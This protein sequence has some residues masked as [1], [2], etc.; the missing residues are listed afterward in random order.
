MSKNLVS[1]LIVVVFLTGCQE[2]V[3]STEKSQPLQE[4]EVTQ[5]VV[6]K[7]S[8]NKS[9]NIEKPTAIK[10]QQPKAAK[11]PTAFERLTQRLIEQ[12]EIALAAERF[13][14]PVDDNANLYFQAALGRDPGNFRAIQGIT[15][16]VDVY[17]QWAWQA[18]RN[19]DYKKA[20]KYL[21]SARSVNPEDPAIIEMTSRVS[22]LKA[23]RE[24]AAK[25]SKT[26]PESKEP[27]ALKEGQFLLPETLFSLSE[28]EI[29]AKIQPIIDEVATAD[30]P[31]AIYWPNDKEAR[32]IYQI[33]NSRV[34]EFR[35]RAMTYHRADYMVELQQD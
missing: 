20:A 18:A 19:G 6:A 10:T 12:G 14:T 23:K 25:I 26:K 27:K 11:V 29:I 8:V 33:I 2:N 1:F 17:T 28:E 9:V 35:V 21:D 4:V 3:K 15:G 32:L 16:I 30:R 34:P 31:I 22:D 13:L 5:A 7:A 24:Q